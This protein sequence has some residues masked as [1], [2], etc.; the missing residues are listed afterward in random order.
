MRISLRRWLECRAPG[1]ADSAVDG[2]GA[3]GPPTQ[4]AL[5]RC[6]FLPGARQP[7]RVPAIAGAPVW[8]RVL[9]REP[10]I[11]RMRDEGEGREKWND[12]MTHP[13]PTSGARGG[14]HRTQPCRA[15]ARRLAIINLSHA[16]DHRSR[17]RTAACSSRLQRGST[18]TRIVRRE[19]E[20]SEAFSAHRQLRQRR[21]LVHAFEH[22][23]H[24]CPPLHRCGG[25]FAFA[26]WDSREERVWL[27]GREPASAIKAALLQGGNHER[28][29]S[30]P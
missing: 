2:L 23:G 26:L 10:Y 12:A 19:L 27:R 30:R 15:R 13:D 21:M 11:T 6:D 24:D 20:Q 22:W 4:P 5:G 1:H 29:V 8:G 9:H 18:T 28:L 25:M 3:N 16:R 17:T 14:F 7:D